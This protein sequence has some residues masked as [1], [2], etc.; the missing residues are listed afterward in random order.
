M[1]DRWQWC[2]LLASDKPFDCFLIFWRPRTIQNFSLNFSMRKL[3]VLCTPSCFLS[4]WRC[5]MNRLMA[6]W[7]SGSNCGG[8][9]FY[10]SSQFAMRPV[11]RMSSLLESQTGRRSWSLTISLWFGASP[12]CR[13]MYISGKA[14]LC[15]SLKMK[16]SAWAKRWSPQPVLFDQYCQQNPCCIM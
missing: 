9:T 5:T 3:R 4:T 7:S 16:S 10:A 14:M 2:D 1:D 12:F 15:T 13:E 6:W 8:S 11:T